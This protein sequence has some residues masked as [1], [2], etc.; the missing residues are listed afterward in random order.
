[1]F[2][3]T[4][5]GG[6]VLISIGVFYLLN[7][8]VFEKSNSWKAFVEALKL[9]ENAQIVVRMM[10]GIIPIIIGLFFVL[11]GVLY[12]NPLDVFCLFKPVACRLQCV[13]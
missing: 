3:P 6:V 5:I 2:I 1:M 7:K 11:I 13:S 4:I 12:T 9:S 8:S 10:S